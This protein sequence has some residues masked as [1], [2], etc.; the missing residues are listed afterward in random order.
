MFFKIGKDLPRCQFNILGPDVFHENAPKS[1]E[2][3][4]QITIQNN[5]QILNINQ[6]TLRVA[7][8]RWAGPSTYSLTE[9]STKMIITR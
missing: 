6:L 7:P 2:N 9:K 3:T 4:I 5:Q 1:K 8:L